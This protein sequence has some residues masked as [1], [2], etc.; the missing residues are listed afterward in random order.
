VRMSLGAAPAQIRALVVGR[1]LG[2]SALGAGVGLAAS[3]AAR[4]LVANQLCG[5]S[6]RP[7]GHPGSIRPASCA[8]GVAGRGPGPRPQNERSTV[9]L[10]W[11]GTPGTAWVT[12]VRL[13]KK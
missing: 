12:D 5:V 2:L 13:P 10:A 3:L 7:A 1:A 11:K 9:S 6:S 4:G 8:R